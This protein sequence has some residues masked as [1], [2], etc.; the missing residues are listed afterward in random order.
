MRT[1]R[2]SLLIL[3]PLALAAVLGAAQERVKKNEPADFRAL[4]ESAQAAYDAG[5]FGACV[6]DLQAAS[7]LAVVQRAKAI[8][9][10]LPAAPAGFA[11]EP[12]ESLEEALASP[13]LGAMALGIGSVVQQTYRAEGRGGSIDVTIQVDSPLLQMFQM[14][15]TNPAMLPKGSEVIKY[16]AHTAVLRDDGGTRNLQLVIDANL[17][18]VSWPNAD[19]DALFAMFDQKAV[20]KLAGVLGS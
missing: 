1:R 20:D 17:V 6:K 11:I 13:M 3:A 7:S 14:W 12:D 15:V 5:R 9:A 2:N 16:G 10:A 18:E 19:E 4:L 8:R